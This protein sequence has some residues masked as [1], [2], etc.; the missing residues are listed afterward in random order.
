MLLLLRRALAEGQ[1]ERATLLD[2]VA[3]A[4]AGAQRAARAQGAAEA[5]AA[6]RGARWVPCCGLAGLGCCSNDICVHHFKELCW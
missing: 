2:K 3:V 1:A 5:A 6:E 4:Q